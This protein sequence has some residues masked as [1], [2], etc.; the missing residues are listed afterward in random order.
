MKCRPFNVNLFNQPLRLSRP[1]ALHDKNMQFVVHSKE[2]DENSGFRFRIMVM[3]AGVV[4]EFDT[5]KALLEKS[6]SIFYGMAADAG[7]V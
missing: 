3:D 5:P 1:F 7:L 4:K 6:D 2:A